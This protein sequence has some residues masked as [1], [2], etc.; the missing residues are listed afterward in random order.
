MIQRQEL[1]NDLL[2]RVEAARTVT[3]IDS[4]SRLWANLTGT[5]QA[6]ALARIAQKREQLVRSGKV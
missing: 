6:S 1:Y 5:D 2:R 3:E 4:L